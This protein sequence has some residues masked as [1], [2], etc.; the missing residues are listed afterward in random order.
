MNGNDEFSKTENLKKILKSR[1]LHRVWG[2]AS[3]EDKIIS[4][5]CICGRY[6]RVV[7]YMCK[8]L[9]CSFIETFAR[10][11]SILYYQL[12]IFHTE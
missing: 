7:I 9:L 8:Y 11:N 1:E 4:E 5:L 6:A 10:S 2:T 12:K 3:R